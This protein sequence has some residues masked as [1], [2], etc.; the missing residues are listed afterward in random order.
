MKMIIA[1]LHEQDTDP[2][3]HALTASDYRVTVIASTGGF[4]R[5]GVSTMLI[6][7]ADEQVDPALALI[8]KSIVTPSTPNSTRATIFVIKVD[9]FTQF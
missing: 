7:V 1:I 3:S 8:R 5:K 6:G 2:V 4:L 9:E